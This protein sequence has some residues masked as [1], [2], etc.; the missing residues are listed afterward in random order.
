LRL[1]RGI[2]G[3]GYSLNVIREEF[4]E[5]FWRYGVSGTFSFNFFYALYSN[6]VGSAFCI[7]IFSHSTDL[8]PSDLRKLQNDYFMLRFGEGITDS[9]VLA[10]SWLLFYTDLGDTEL[11]LLKR[12]LADFSLNKFFFSFSKHST[13]LML[14]FFDLILINSRGLGFGLGLTT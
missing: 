7:S 2:Y 1:V 13:F 4:N 11:S 3:V 14:S 5:V 6:S 8:L 9:R 10:V 12:S